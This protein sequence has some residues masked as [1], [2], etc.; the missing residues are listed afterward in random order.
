MPEQA[1]PRPVPKKSI[2]A[3]TAAII[4]A[5][6]ALEGGY[7]QLRSDPGGETNFGV[8][9]VVA[10]Q[11][12]YTGPMRTMPREVAESIYY[13]DY[14]VRPGYADLVPHDAAVA[15]ELFDTTVNM[16]SARPSR[17]FQQSLD[18]LCTARRPVTGHVVR[19]DVD[20]Y[21][22]CQARVGPA[23]LCLQTLQSLDGAQLAEYGRL[24]RV[25][26]RLRVFYKG[27]TRNRIG[28]VDRRKC[29]R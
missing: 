7:V 3:A 11:H 6:I 23:R 28:N 16:G 27:W 10:R 4:A 21:V 18:A 29:G 15:E 12:G 25:N 19:G 24:V 8:T 5:T 22:V 2:G 17:W 1:S 9:K 13:Q 14:L 20:A 26:P